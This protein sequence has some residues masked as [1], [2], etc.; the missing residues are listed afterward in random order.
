MVFGDVECFVDKILEMLHIGEERVVRNLACLF[1][2]LRVGDNALQV[3]K[4]FTKCCLWY[5]KA[6]ARVTLADH[7][8]V[9]STGIQV[10]GADLSE[11]IDE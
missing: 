11:R 10:A 7:F 3:I 6:T 9:L 1:C 8:R 4:F 5:Q 2:F